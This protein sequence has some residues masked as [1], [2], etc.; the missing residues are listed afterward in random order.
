MLLLTQKLSAATWSW[1]IGALSK[2]IKHYFESNNIPN[3]FCD[4]YGGDCI[5]PQS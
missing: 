1:K 2:Y 3:A 5:I 4:Y